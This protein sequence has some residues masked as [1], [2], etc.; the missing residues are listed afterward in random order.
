MCIRDRPGPV[1]EAQLPEHLPKPTSITLRR[2]R[3]TR[4][5]GIEIADTDVERILRALGMQV[6]AIEEGLSLIHI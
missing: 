2:A 1:V 6:E 3:I 5:L 4:L